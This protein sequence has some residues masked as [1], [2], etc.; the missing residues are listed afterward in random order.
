MSD[1]KADLEAAFGRTI[2]RKLSRL[3]DPSAQV[4]A[5]IDALMGVGLSE[6]QAR[7]VRAA[8]AVAEAGLRPSPAQPP[9]I[10]G[11]NDAWGWF[12]PHM[13]GLAVEEVHALY[14]NRRNHVLGRRMISRGSD[15]FAVV[16]ARMVLRPAVEMGA[17]GVVLAHNHPSGD[18]SPSRQ[19]REVTVRLN[20]ACRT[21]GL[22]LLDHLILAGDQYTSFAEEGTLSNYDAPPPLIV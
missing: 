6:A 9:A 7:R 15:G 19:D 20:L 17:H 5:S 21:L 18:P 4:L 11:P 12:H 8:F 2:A 14:L 13:R 22:R 16:D 10:S 3:G 1:I